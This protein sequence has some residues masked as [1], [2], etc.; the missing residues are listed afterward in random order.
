MARAEKNAR[1][2]DVSNSRLQENAQVTHA[3]RPHTGPGHMKIG[4]SD[5]RFA[6]Q[7]GA[8]EALKQFLYDEEILIKGVHVETIDLGSLNNLKYAADGRLPTEDEWR[9]LDQKLV[10]LTPML[11]PE[12]RWKLR[13][14]Q[15]SFF[16]RTLPIIS[17][18]ASVVTTYCLIVI[19]E[20]IA[21]HNSVLYVILYTGTNIVWT[22]SQ[23]ALGACAFLSISVMALI[24]KKRALSDG[25]Y[26]A[27][28]ITD[29]TILA[30]R[31]ILGALFALLLGLPVAGSALATI[32]LS[33]KSGARPPPINDYILVLAPFMFGFSTTLVLSIFDR[34]VKGI[35]VLFGVSRE[36]KRGE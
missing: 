32:W 26:P 23:G 27:V 5:R 28:D 6:A 35:G 36:T 30:A 12:L 3:A 11:T 7:L 33:F 1:S 25:L 31:V 22:I 16:F 29:K 17:I 20:L 14:R 21:D 10:A 13:V 18:L 34:I 8:I 2:A 19:N 24:S 15:L 9:A 4:I